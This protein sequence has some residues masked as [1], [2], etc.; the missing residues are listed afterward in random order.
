MMTAMTMMPAGPRP[1]LS[2]IFGFSELGPVPPVPP[3]FLFPSVSASDGSS[4]S[5][6]GYQCNADLVTTDRL[7][8]FENGMLVFYKTCH[9]SRICELLAWT[10]KSHACYSDNLTIW[11]WCPSA[12]LARVIYLW[13][14]FTFSADPSL[15]DM[16]IDGG[17]SYF[18]L[19][20]QRWWK[21]NLAISDVSYSLLRTPLIQVQ[22][23]KI[24]F[25]NDYLCSG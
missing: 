18:S 21:T 16:L 19:N 17:C 13:F 8:S 7:Y 1:P 5:L 3:V 12:H 23:E 9:P 15:Q 25:G 20:S 11:S 6:W 24:F 4:L 2:L 22:I 10:E 14:A